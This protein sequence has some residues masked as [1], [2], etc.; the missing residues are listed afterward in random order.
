MA[1]KGAV[2][3]ARMYFCEGIPLE[4]MRM[5][6]AQRKRIRVAEAVFR[7][8]E[9]DNFLD[10]MRCLMRV[11]KR[12]RAEALRDKEV[13]DAF[14]EWS[15][16]IPRAR[17]ER[18]L[19][20]IAENFVRIGEQTGDWKPTKQGADLLKYLISER[21][22]EEN[23]VVRNTA[24]LPAVL[25]DVS[26]IDPTKRALT[27]DTLRAILKKYGGKPD[28]IDEMIHQREEQL[29]LA[30]CRAEEASKG[31]EGNDIKDYIDY[32]E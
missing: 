4:D 8:F 16:Q 26:Y 22:D 1:L 23:S 11:Y 18:Q 24:E 27:D 3:Q 31:E 25:V 13:V 9:Q 12:T 2:E 28:Q 17:L 7:H 29:L 10:I 19:Y 21:P 20:G 5:T 6:E 15:S 14:I 30:D 32:E